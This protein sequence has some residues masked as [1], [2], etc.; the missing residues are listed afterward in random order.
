MTSLQ[1][2]LK[3]TPLVCVCGSKSEDVFDKWTP[4]K[5]ESCGKKNTQDLMLDVLQKSYV[6]TPSLSCL[7]RKYW[8]VHPQALQRLHTLL[9]ALNPH[10]VTNTHEMECLWCHHLE[11]STKSCSTA[12]LSLKSLHPAS[13]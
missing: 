7:R 8:H 3:L 4:E 6:S 9:P 11:R 5:E 2:L 1:H 13:R 10:T 12:E